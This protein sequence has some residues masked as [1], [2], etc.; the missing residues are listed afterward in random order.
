[1]VRNGDA[2]MDI[3]EGTSRD[4]FDGEEAKTSEHIAVRVIRQHGGSNAKEVMYNAWVYVLK[5]GRRLAVER[6]TI[7]FF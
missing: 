5:L 2:T 1:M 6:A 7:S 3:N 4:G